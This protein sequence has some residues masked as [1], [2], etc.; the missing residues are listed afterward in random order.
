MGK[1][2]MPGGGGGG[3]SSDDCTL[4]RAAVPYGMKAVTADS[5]DEAMEGTLNPDTTLADSQALSGQTFLKWN[6]QTKLFER[7]TGNMANKGAWNS[8]IG[9]NG[10]IM[11][12]AGYHNGS[13]YVD[14]ALTAKGAATY[15]P[16]RS[17]QVIGA[18]QWLS[19]AQT[20]LGD[21]NLKPENIKKG[22]PIFGNMGT[23][24]GY[25]TSPLYL[26]NNGTWGGLQTTGM[27]EVT[28]KN[29]GGYIEIGSSIEFGG[30]RGNQDI[31]NARLNQKFN[32]TSYKYIKIRAEYYYYSNYI[33]IGVSDSPNAGLGGYI[34]STKVNNPNGGYYI[35]DVSSISGEK[36]IYLEASTDHGFSNNSSDVVIVHEIMVTNN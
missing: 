28:D 29:G 34:A 2:W 31:L 9:I 8:R 19:G 4:L 5:D 17:N 16:G 7:H 15:T 6:P 36:Y 3:A 1:I 13:G 20:I 25:V 23:H 14:Q 18:N 27:T 33:M 21:P 24:E 12:P 10:K 35:L 11:I 22:V 32:L 26:F 30:R